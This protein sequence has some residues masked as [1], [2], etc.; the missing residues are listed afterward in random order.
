VSEFHEFICFFIEDCIKDV[1]REHS[2][3]NT[4]SCEGRCV[5]EIDAE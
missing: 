3:Y 5:V 4:L 2:G 1:C